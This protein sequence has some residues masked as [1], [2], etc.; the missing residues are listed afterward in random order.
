MEDVVEL[1]KMFVREKVVFLGNS[2]FLTGP[3]DDG[4][5]AKDHNC[6]YFIQGTSIGL[7]MTNHALYSLVCW[8]CDSDN[9]NVNANVLFCAFYD[10]YIFHYSRLSL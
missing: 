9:K 4:P 2:F 3:V 7:A 10:L 8:N 5:S 1:G 6:Y